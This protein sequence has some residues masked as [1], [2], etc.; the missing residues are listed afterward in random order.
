MPIFRVKSV[1]IYTG[2]FFLHRHVGVCDKYQ[3]CTGPSDYDDNNYDFDD[4]EVDNDDGHNGD[5]DKDDEND[6]AYADDD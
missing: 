1:N 6:D 5:I 2:Q 3:V 4:D